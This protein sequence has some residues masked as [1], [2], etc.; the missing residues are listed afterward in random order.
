M[1]LVQALAALAATARAPSSVAPLSIEKQLEVYA[2][3]YLPFDPETKVTVTKGTETIPGFQGYRVKRTGR[4]AKLNVDR[5]VYVSEDGRWFFS[6]DVLKNSAPRPVRTES[7]LGWVSG[8]YS[9]LFRTRVRVLLI[10]ERDLAGWKG[11]ALSIETGYGTVSMA[12]SV[13]A[14]GSSFLQGMFWDFRMDPREERRRRIDLSAGRAQGPADATVTVVEYADMECP[15]CKMRSHQMGQL[16]QTNAG[17]VNVR[18]HYKFFP[19]WSHHVWAMKAASAG[20][21]LFRLAGPAFFRFK[22]QVYSRQETLS[23]SGIDELALASAEAEGVSSADFL[24][25]YLRDES[26][27]RVRRDIEEGY[28]LGVNSTPTYF[29]D[30]T[31]ITWI[32]DKIMEEFLRTLFPKMKSIEYEAPQK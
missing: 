16:L 24:S 27:A 15:S 13:S 12:G 1:V 22:E 4:Y 17:I 10:P 6:G 18:R 7:D 26:L 2:A 30:G 32:E 29:V 8:K 14:D 5:V 25:C 11:V 28:R 9:T 21:C 20:D 31:E 3:R 19:L 23:V